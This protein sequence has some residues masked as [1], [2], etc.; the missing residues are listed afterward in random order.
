MCTVL[1]TFWRLELQIYFNPTFLKLQ[2]KTEFEL[3][4]V[5]KDPDVKQSEGKT[6]VKHFDTEI[7]TKLEPGVS[8]G[9]HIPPNHNVFRIFQ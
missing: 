1:V 6:K 7:T 8:F 5:E 3:G 2:G 9:F 4:V